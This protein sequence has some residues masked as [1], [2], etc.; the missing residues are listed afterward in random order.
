M[1]LLFSSA[2]ALPKAAPAPDPVHQ[3]GFGVGRGAGGAQGGLSPLDVG[4]G[5]GHGGGCVPTAEEVS[6][7][8]G[9]ADYPQ[10]A[11]EAETDESAPPRVEAVEA[12]VVRVSNSSNR[13]GLWASR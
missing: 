11:A 13:S 10:G 1:A 12:G 8:D 9:G 6:R 4:R 3:P 2:E 7:L 5:S